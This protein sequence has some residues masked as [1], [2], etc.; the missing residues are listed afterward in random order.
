M[1][2]RPSLILRVTYALAIVLG[3]ITGIFLAEMF[4]SR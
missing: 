4:L 2:T 1:T 3:G